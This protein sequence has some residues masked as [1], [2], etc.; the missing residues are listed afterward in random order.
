M[1]RIINNKK[2]DYR[3]YE[4]IETD[5]TITLFLE[6]GESQDHQRYL[7][8]SKKLI[9]SKEDNNEYVVLQALINDKLKEFENGSLLD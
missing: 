9:I 4:H 2:A 6:Y 1:K 5:D 8:K 3:Q 7:L